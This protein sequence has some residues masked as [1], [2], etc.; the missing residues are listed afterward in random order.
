M[1]RAL[2]PHVDE[3]WAESFILELRLLGMAGDRIGGAL[4]EVESHC[5]ESGQS[6]EHAFGPPIDYARTLQPQVD[7]DKSPRAMLHLLIPVMVQVVGMTLLNWSFEDWVRDQ[8]LEITTGHLVSASV[9]FL[10]MMA[11]LLFIDSLLRMAVHHWIRAAILMTFASLSTTA[12][13]V[14]VLLL[15]DETIWRAS[16]GWGLAAGASVLAGGVG[17]ALARLRAGG[18]DEDLITSP[19]DIADRSSSGETRGP[20]QRLFRPSLISGL[21]NTG[22]IPVATV[23]LLA[24]TLMTYQMTPR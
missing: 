9:G 15:L 1:E 2:A 3:T 23:F 12:T 21:I 5:G 20:L 16:A 6:A 11:V 4:S 13:G 8:Q 10:A 24:L 7:D 18:S 14:A 17:W 19:F 22:M